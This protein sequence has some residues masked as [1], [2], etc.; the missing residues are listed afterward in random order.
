MRAFGFLVLFG[1]FR[2][3]P[4]F[5]Q[6]VRGIK[7]KKKLRVWVKKLRKE[8]EDVIGRLAAVVV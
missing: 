7:K 6:S 5:L 1:V 4:P 8:S 2:S 3:H